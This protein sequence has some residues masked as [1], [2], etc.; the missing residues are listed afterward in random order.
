MIRQS[1]FDAV[2]SLDL[3]PQAIIGRPLSYFASSM[4]ADFVSGHD[5]LDQFEGAVFVLDEKF[6]FALKW[7][8]GHPKGTTTIYLP[9]E[10]S[11]LDDITKIV[12]MIMNELR[13]DEG[14]LV[15]QRADNPDL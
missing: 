2:Q 5:D 6:H 3:I 13:L 11:G 8:R 4:H 1:S 12:S 10:F 15:W 14:T 7:Y 9:H